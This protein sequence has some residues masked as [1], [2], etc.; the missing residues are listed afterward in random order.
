MFRLDNKVAI[1]TGG[2]SGI[3]K[4]IAKIFAKQGGEVYILDMNEEASAEVV[5]DL[6]AAGSI[7]AFRKCD[8]SNQEEVKKL[9]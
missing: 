3:G 9:V 6:I 8:V 2:G 4:A 1:I 7:A 5:K